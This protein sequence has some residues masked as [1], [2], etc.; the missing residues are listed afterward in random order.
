MDGQSSE[1]SNGHN[2]TPMSF[3]KFF[4]KPEKEQ[5]FTTSQAIMTIF[6]VR[7]YLWDW[8]S[9]YTLWMR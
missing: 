3:K 2:P 4:E 7:F 1:N 9:M 8:V 6:Y 5:T